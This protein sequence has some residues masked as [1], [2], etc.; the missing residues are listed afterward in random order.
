MQAD[1]QVDSAAVKE[2][3]SG[4]PK[5]SKEA[6][7]TTINKYGLPNEASAS[8][9]IW[10][11]NGP[12]RRTVIYAEEV[13][14]EFQRRITMC[15][16]SIFP[17]RCRSKS[18]GSLRLLT[19]A[20]SSTKGEISARCEGE[21]ANFLALNLANEIVQGHKSVD[22]ARDAYGDAMKKMRGGTAPEIMQKLLFDVPSGGTGEP[23]QPI[24]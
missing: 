5:V 1:T 10:H 3:L 15:W 7:T 11:N 23:D 22:E 9:L 4:W 8:R 14:H 13:P 18:S 20:F 24:I 2:I 16:S 12:W 19:A 17:T 6:A 21:E